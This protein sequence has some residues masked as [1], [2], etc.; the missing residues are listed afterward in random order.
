MRKIILALGLLGLPAVAGATDLRHAERDGFKIDYTVS[1]QADGSHL[2]KGTELT[3]REAFTFHVK[4]RSVTGDVG[5]RPVSFLVSKT[6]AA[7]LDRR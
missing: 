4:G 3:S 1:P 7:A 6:D 5:G 2:I